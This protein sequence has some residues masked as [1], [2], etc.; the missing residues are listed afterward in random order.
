MMPA[1]M[2]ALMIPPTMK[3]AKPLWMASPQ[4]MSVA[5]F[6]HGTPIP[7]IASWPAQNARNAMCGLRSA[8]SSARRP[9]SARGDDE[10]DEVAAG[11]APDDVEA[12]RAVAVDRQE[13]AE[14]RRRAAARPRRAASRAPRRR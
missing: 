1:P 7:K 6:S 5:T 4:V 14:Q 8:P 10:A 3:I 13:Q 9:M 2:I 11:R 12:R